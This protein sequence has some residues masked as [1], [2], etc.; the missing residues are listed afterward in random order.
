MFSGLF[1]FE[2]LTPFTLGGCNF[3]ISN[4]FSTIVIVSDAPRRGVQVLV[5]TPETMERSS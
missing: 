2:F 1:F 5:W 4:Q 3:L